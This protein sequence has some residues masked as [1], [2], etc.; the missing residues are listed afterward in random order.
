MIS[1]GLYLVYLSLSY[2]RVF[3]VFLTGLIPYR[4][5]LALGLVALAAALL[6][7]FTGHKTA[8]RLDHLALFLTL[9]AWVGI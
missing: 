1:F 6:R 2:I 4:P 5:M 7:L 8:L 9:L 3:D